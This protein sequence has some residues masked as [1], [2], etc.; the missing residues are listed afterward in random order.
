ME[1]LFTPQNATTI[2]G[3]LAAAF[4]ALAVLEAA[5]GLVLAVRRMK[6]EKLG[7]LAERLDAGAAE[8]ERAAEAAE[9]AAP[10]PKTIRAAEPATRPA[11]EKQV[12]PA[13]AP[14][15]RPA[16]PSLR[17]VTPE[18]EAEP[19]TRPAEPSL[20]VVVS[21]PEPE[22][23]EEAPEAAPKPEPLRVVIPEPVVAPAP[24]AP[25]T[26]E[27]LF[28]RLKAG[29]AKT[30]EALFGNIERLLTG[31][32]A[33]DD[34][35]FEQL[36]EVLV[37]A[38]LG[39]QTAYKLL[40]SLEEKYRRKELTNADQLKRTLKAEMRALLE[41]DYPPMK[42]SGKPSVIL[43]VGVN[44]VGKTTTIGKLGALYARQGKKVVLA[45][46]DTFRAAAVD[47]IQIWANR[48]GVDVV[49]HKDGSDPAAVV[50]DACD[51]AVARGAD[52]VIA[53]TAGRL[54]TKKNLMEELKKI[55]RA[56]QKKIPEGPHEVLLV[57]DATTGQNAIAQ[58]REF[59]EAVALTGLVLTKLDGTAKGGIIVGISDELGIP[60]RYIG[61]GE[62]V[63]DLRPFEPQEFIDALY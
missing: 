1:Q 54:H 38:D 4:V 25:P 5:V 47:Q 41:R 9:A 28:A 32:E 2:L 53:D 45:A 50:F 29:L 35:T 20:R 24:E 31:K 44:G 8:A 59:N 26:K 11:P 34:E 7:R 18:P 39:V 40:R 58:A 6:E 3:W 55:S 27:G 37:T 56:V 52:L 17:V 16:P 21:E 63:D 33:L 12:E 60:V 48:A 19:A 61:V 13:P 62:Q 57:L 30:R 43:I 15:T 46:A 14:A 51:A 36:E 22:P 10:G 23:E 49:K 42:L